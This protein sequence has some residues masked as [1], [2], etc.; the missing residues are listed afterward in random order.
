MADYHKPPKK[1]GKKHEVFSVNLRLKLANILGSARLRMDTFYNGGEPPVPPW[2]ELWVEE[3]SW[4]EVQP[5]IIPREPGPWNEVG[6]TLALDSVKPVEKKP[7]EKK[8]VK[9]KR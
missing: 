4:W 1:P 8:P 5:E 9:K 2:G 3:G 6:L 7:V